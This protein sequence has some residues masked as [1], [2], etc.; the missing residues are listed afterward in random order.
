MVLS[1][2]KRKRI[3]KILLKSISKYDVFLGL[4]VAVYIIVWSYITISRFY[5]LN[6]LIYDLGAYMQRSWE[7]IYFRL[8]IVQYVNIMFSSGLVYLVFPLA[9]AKS[10]P[11]LLF[12]QSFLIGVSAFAV[13]GIDKHFINDRLVS[14]ILSVSFLLYF[15]MAGL[16]WYDLHYQVYFIPLFMFGFFFYL[17]GHFKIAFILLAL[18]GIVRYPFIVFPFLFSLI[19]ILQFIYSENRKKAIQ[20]LS[21]RFNIALFI[22]STLFLFFSALYLQLSGTGTTSIIHASLLEPLGYN[23]SNKAVTIF[24]YLL[25]VLFFPL[26]SK[27]WAPLLIPY[28]GL[29]FVTDFFG[30]VY[31]TSIMFQYSTTIVPFIYISTI[32]TLSTLPNK[33]GKKKWI[34]SLKLNSKVMSRI[35]VSIM[36]VL[37]LLLSL[38]Y[39]P[40]GPFNGSAPDNF[41]IENSLHPNMTNYNELNSIISLI[42]SNNS[43]I[44]TQYNIPEIIPRP[45]DNSPFFYITAVTLTYNLSYESQNGEWTR[46]DIQYIL[47]DYDSTFY[48]FSQAFPY[49][50]SMSTIIQNVYSTGHFGI[51]A[52]SGPFILLEKGYVGNPVIYIPVQIKQQVSNFR[53]LNGPFLAPNGVVFNNYSYNSGKIIVQGDQFIHYGITLYPGIYKLSL[54][55][56]SQSASYSNTANISISAANSLYTYNKTTING[57]YF[58]NNC[59]YNVTLLLKIP[60]IANNV[61]V[62]FSNIKWNGSLELKNL[63]INQMVSG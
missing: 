58:S 54:E 5:S 62:V 44:L 40:Y 4:S 51:L 36:L 9:M 28:F 41:N 60:W 12:I 59:T 55:L 53:Y 3:E 38:Y 52:E 21:F 1:N 45:L 15:P 61:Y 29:M 8:T 31:P 48:Y 22:F 32:E 56:A 30:Y 7:I 63:R 11:L 27:K 49:N 25:P 42:P 37:T 26:L 35:F 17:K 18:S 33:G 57:I 10:Y 24:I 13:Y 19:E 20:I 50:Y 46:A 47:A 43:N 2:F 39:Q 6:A 14:L 34:K 23:I 16:N